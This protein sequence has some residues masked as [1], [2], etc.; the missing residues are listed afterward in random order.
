MSSVEHLKSYVED[1]GLIVSKER[2]DYLPACGRQHSLLV[3][4]STIDLALPPGRMPSDADFT[5][6]GVAAMRVGLDGP[7]RW[8]SFGY[9]LLSQFS[10][11]PVVAASLR[12]ATG[13]EDQGVRAVV[14]S[15]AESMVAGSDGFKYR[16]ATL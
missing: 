7:K 4:W 3:L 2:R 9:C 5:R 14:S 16:P 15:S 6:I 12:L 8:R 10:Q 13:D 11:I 1:A